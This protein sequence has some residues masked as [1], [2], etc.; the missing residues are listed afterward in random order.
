M[1]ARRQKLHRIRKVLVD[2]TINTQ[3][4]P[5]MATRSNEKKEKY[6][7]KENPTVIDGISSE[8]TFN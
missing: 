4:K 3:G 7:A 5:N 1:I 8:Y 6:I 2:N